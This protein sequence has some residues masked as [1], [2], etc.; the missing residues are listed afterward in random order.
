[1]SEA[2][3][4]K[5]EGGSDVLELQIGKF[6]DDLNAREP[7]R[8]QIEDVAHADAHAPDT[9]PAPALRRVHG[10]SLGHG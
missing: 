2:P 1:M 8:Q 5:A 6:F 9:G 4:G 10:D 3:T 7:G